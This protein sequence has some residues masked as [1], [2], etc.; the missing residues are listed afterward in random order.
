MNAKLY[1][2]WLF[3][4]KN[5]FYRIQIIPFLHYF[6]IISET[7]DDIRAILNEQKRNQ[8]VVGFVPTMGA[9]HDGHISLIHRA[10]LQ[11]N[12]VVASIF[13]N[14]AQFNNEQ[15]LLLYPRN[16]DK[17]IEML[18]SAGC[19]LLFAPDVSEI[20]SKNKSLTSLSFGEI[21]Y[22]MEGKFRPGHFAGV[23][24]VVSKLFNIIQPDVAFFGEKDFQQL[25]IIR[26]LV[27]DLNFPIQVVGV[28]TVREPNGLALSSRNLRLTEEQKE[29]ASYLFRGLLR[30]KNLVDNKMPIPQ[31]KL[32]IEKYFSELEGIQLEYLTVVD[33]STLDVVED[34]SSTHSITACVA[35]YVGNVRIIDNINLL[36]I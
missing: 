12:V 16:L 21:E 35:A 25:A 5:G 23:G 19:D 24:L 4:N 11:S 18:K 33:S 14:P 6:M 34:I 8:K 20:Y 29:I 17:D 3:F 28:E 13:V 22:L 10:K 26:S 2:F 7:I 9:L 1:Y 31:A 36:K 32:E 27:D 15:D 30:L